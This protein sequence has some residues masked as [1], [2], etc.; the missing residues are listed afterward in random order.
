LAAS[1]L[2]TKDQ[3]QAVLAYLAS[4]GFAN[5]VVADNNLLV[6]ASGTA[7]AI[8]SAFGTEMAH[9]SKGGHAAIANLSDVTVPTELGGIVQSVLGLQTLDTAEVATVQTLSPTLFPTVYDS[10][11]LA[12]ASGT[13]D[14]HHR[15]GPG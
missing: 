4:N 6:T 14:R 2:P 1:Y 3:V 9:F 11:G 8:R 12:T 15:V 7:K 5:V 13:H 10:T